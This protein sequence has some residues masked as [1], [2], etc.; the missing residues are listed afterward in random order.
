MDPQEIVEKVSTECG[1]YALYDNND[2]LQ[3]IGIKRNIAAIISG[4]WKSQRVVEIVETQ[5]VDY[6]TVDVLDEQFKYGLK[7]TLKQYNNWLTFPQIFVNGE[8]LGGCDILTELSVF[9][10]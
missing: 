6:E 10:E 5:G 4:H 8:L 2:D 9:T 3:F 7:E 1:V